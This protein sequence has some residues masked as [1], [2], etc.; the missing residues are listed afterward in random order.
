MRDAPAA[1]V[2]AGGDAGLSATDNHHV[3][4]LSRGADAYGKVSP[5]PGLI[6][7][8]SSSSRSERAA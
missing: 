3:H 7:P 1:E 2:L 4:S 8:G 6:S 5:P